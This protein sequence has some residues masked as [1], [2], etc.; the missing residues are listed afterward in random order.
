MAA[1]TKRS[2]IYLEPNLHKALRL[3][4]A[5]LEASMSDIVNDALRIVFEED[6]EDLMDIKMRQAEK[7]V[8]FDDFVTELKAS[9]QL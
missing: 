8:S 4:A 9:G 2:T 6:A 1:K 5:E 3:K 7:S